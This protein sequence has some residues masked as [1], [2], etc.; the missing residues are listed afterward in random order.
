V[1]FAQNP[2]IRREDDLEIVSRS[3][4][5]LAAPRPFLLGQHLQHLPYLTFSV[6]FPLFP[7]QREQLR[8]AA[9]LFLRGNIV[10]PSCAF[11]PGPGGIGEGVE[12]VDRRI[13]E[14]PH[15]LPEIV[16]G[17]SGKPGHDVRSDRNPGDPA[18][19][20]L[21]PFEILPGGVG[22]SHPRKGPVAPALQGNME[23]GTNPPARGRQV[24][25]RIGDL[26][27]LDRADADPG[28]GG[29]L[30]QSENQVR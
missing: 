1:Q 15:R 9:F 12:V 10:P 2:R 28:P 11:G 16:L 24:D 18:S 27:G 4:A 19:D 21:D 30:E 13:P 23:V 25:Q 20:P 29:S 26:V 3:P 8:D 7:V 5:D 17:L 14:N 22:P 6:R